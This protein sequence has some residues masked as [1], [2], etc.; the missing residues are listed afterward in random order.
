MNLI[1]ALLSYGLLLICFAAAAGVAI[2]AGIIM[3]KRKDEKTES[4]KKEEA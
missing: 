4:E 1:S 3:R 2:C